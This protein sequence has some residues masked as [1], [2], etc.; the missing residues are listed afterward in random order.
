MSR[1]NEAHGLRGTILSLPQ[2]CPHRRNIIK[3][4]AEWLQQ[5]GCAHQTLLNPCDPVDLF[6][7]SFRRVRDAWTTGPQAV[8]LE[9]MFEALARGG[10]LGNINKIVCFRLGSFSDYSDQD[11]EE[12]LL[13]F[14]LSA[15][16]HAAILLLASIISRQNERAIEVFAHDREYHSLE[17]VILETLGIQAATGYEYNDESQLDAYG[18]DLLVSIDNKTLVFAPNTSVELQQKICLMTRPGGLVWCP[19]SVGEPSNNRVLLQFSSE[20]DHHQLSK[21]TKRRGGVT[22]TDHEKK[23]VATDGEEREN[24]DE[25][26]DD[27]DDTIKNEYPTYNSES[28][29]NCETWLLKGEYQTRKEEADAAMQD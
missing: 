7:R 22:T 17:K 27:S 6:Y 1:E 9:S 11:H 10:Q 2:D 20:Y 12:Q 23:H 13:K 28:L 25:D 24:E 26:K 8:A 21:P 15:V 19:K 5:P 16:Y 29:W 4:C 3:I 14:K 18:H